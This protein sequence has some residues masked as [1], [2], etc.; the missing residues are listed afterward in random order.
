MSLGSDKLVR[1][2][3]TKNDEELSLV[4][5]EPG[6]SS[7]RDNSSITEVLFENVTDTIRKI[8]TNGSVRSVIRNFITQRLIR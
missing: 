1:S 3:C 6:I 4:G 7:Q 2:L 5:F 8:H